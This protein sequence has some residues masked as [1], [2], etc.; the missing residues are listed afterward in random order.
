MEFEIPELKFGKQHPETKFTKKGSK[1]KRPIVILTSN[2]EKSLPEAFLRRCVFFHIEFP[3]EKE[4]IEILKLKIKDIKKNISDNWEV[5]V[6]FFN[7][8]RKIVTRKKPAT[9]ELIHWVYLL[10]NLDFDC[11]KLMLFIN[12]KEFNSKYNKDIDKL[13]FDNEDKRN[14]T[15]S[16]TVLA[17]NVEDL[18]KL[19]NS[20]DEK[21]TTK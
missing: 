4:L 19:V 1:G 8:N 10:N 13:K 7:E 5:L 12:D 6:K 17:K 16:F 14:L 9:S 20:I 11:K 21:L 18:K 3:T 2:S 15:L